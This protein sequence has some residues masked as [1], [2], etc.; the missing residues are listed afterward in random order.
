MTNEE[1]ID[2]NKDKLNKEQI[3]ELNKQNKKEVKEQKREK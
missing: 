2:K 3:K 1:F